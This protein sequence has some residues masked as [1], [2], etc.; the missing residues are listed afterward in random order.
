MNTAYLMGV[1]NMEVAEICDRI[2]AN[3]AEEAAPRSRP[4]D[5][6]NLRCP[7]APRFDR[8]SQEDE[9]DER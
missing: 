6:A 7:D 5:Q 2:L 9:T 4:S 3:A 1:I 8:L